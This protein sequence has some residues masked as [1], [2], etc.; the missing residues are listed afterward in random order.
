MR[1][2]KIKLCIALA[3]RDWTM[4][5]LS[6]ECKVSRQTISNIKNGKS[7]PFLTAVKIAEALGVE[8]T[9]LLED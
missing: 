1:I 9:D 8:V 3:K 7:C 4:E 2:N 6:K 5:Q